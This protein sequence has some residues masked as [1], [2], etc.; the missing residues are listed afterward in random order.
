MQQRPLTQGLP[1]TSS[2][3]FASFDENQCGARGQSDA[4][5]LSE[6][7]ADAPAAL[8]DQVRFIAARLLPIARC[9]LVEVAT[10]LGMHE[11]TLQR[12]LADEGCVFEALVDDVRRYEASGYLGEP[13]LSMAR[14]AGLVGYQEQSSFNRAAKR[15]FGMT[16]RAYRQQLLARQ[17]RHARDPSPPVIK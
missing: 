16:P 5:Y 8:G 2:L 3:S 15:W 12:R 6:A 4:R 11:R 14:I 10:Q 9:G 1:R 7:G 17:W 13:S